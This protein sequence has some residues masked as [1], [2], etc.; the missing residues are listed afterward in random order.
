VNTEVWVWAEHYQGE[1]LGV[2]LGLLNKARELCQQLGGGEVASVLFGTQSQRLANELIDYGSDKVYLADDP[3]LSP[4]DTELRARLMANII[5][6]HQPEIVLWGAS[7]LESETASRVAAKLSTG[8][9]AHCI[10]LS[11][12]EIDGRHQL[13]TI[14]AG[15]GGNLSLKIICPEKRPVMATIKPGIFPPA[16]PQRRSGQVISV[17]V[18]DRASRLEIIE[19]VEQQKEVAGLEQAEVVVVGGWGLYSL[20]GFQAVDELAQVLGG[21]AAGTRPALD[22]G[23]IPRERMIGQSGQIVAPRLLVTL[24]VSGAP[25]FAT[26]VLGSRLILAVDKNPDAPIFEMADIGIVG[27]LQEVLPLLIEKVRRIRSQT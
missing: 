14:V 3:A 6:D 19:V 4:F 23:W 17:P 27:D 15:W 7:S 25:Q 22:A 20:G 24:G 18:E 26:G 10:D 11:I 8:L 1:L 12:E 5:Q 16:V 21:I 2:S 13:V 9:T